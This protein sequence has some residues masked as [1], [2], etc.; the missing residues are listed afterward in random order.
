M[1][2][3]QSCP[4]CNFCRP[5]EGQWLISTL[6]INCNNVNLDFLGNFKIIIFS[7]EKLG[8]MYNQKK[9]LKNIQ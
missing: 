3:D 8:Y 1:Q 5:Q 7:S 4:L 6:L 2:R 9:I